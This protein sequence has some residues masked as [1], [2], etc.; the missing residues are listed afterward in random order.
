MKS[1]C[2]D[3]YR[4]E[5]KTENGVE[6]EKIL[7]YNDKYCYTVDIEMLRV[8]SVFLLSDSGHYPIFNEI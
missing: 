2:E 4:R 6:S 3:I 8:Q 5:P 1:K 7:E